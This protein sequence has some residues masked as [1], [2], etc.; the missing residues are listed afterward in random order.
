[1][2]ITIV[3]KKDAQITFENA[4]IK[5][6]DQKLPA[7]LVDVLLI[8]NNVNFDSKEIIKITDTGTIIVLFSSYKQRSTIISSTEVKNSE[9]KMKQYL[10]I[11]KSLE[12]A[13]FLIIEKIKRHSYQLSL[14]EITLNIE[15]I[16]KKLQTVQ[17]HEELLG[18]EGSFARE[19][20]KN[21]FS[22]IP[23]QFHKNVRS[24]Q[25]PMDPANALLSYF[26]SMTYNIITV[27]L[28]TFGFETGIGYLHKPFRDHHALSSDIMELFR[29]QINQFVIELFREPN[30]LS[31]DD[32]TKKGGVY[33]SFEGKR[34]L[35]EYV[36]DLM[37][38]LDF[39][40]NSELTNL[41]E[42]L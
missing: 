41:K 9:L 2:N 39:K 7:R 3:D 20:F 29:D 27:K 18:I 15:P 23:S 14:N 31:M 32:F 12:I 24:K 10:A 6:D 37:N 38:G 26:Y 11:P 33:L 40:I 34:K 1:M 30:L 5:I 36:K 17:N 35:H 42:M 8:M 16:L 19:Y 28:I 25:P 4:V 22:L 13:K 21:F